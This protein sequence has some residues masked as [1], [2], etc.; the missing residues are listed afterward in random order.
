MRYSAQLR[1]S[2]HKRFLLRVHPGGIIGFD[3]CPVPRIL[4]AVLSDCGEQGWTGS[5]VSCDRRQGIAERFGHSSQAALYDGWIH[6]RPGFLP[7]NPPGRSTHERRSD[8]VP[9]PGPLG[10]WLRPYQTGID[11]TEWDELVAVAARLGYALHKP[12]SSASEAHHV[13][14]LTDP[15]YQLTKRGLR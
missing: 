12:Y 2:R 13:N 10:R 9:Y 14:C 6:H 15:T 4:A 11:V 7:A 3:G 1:T 8:S 5:V